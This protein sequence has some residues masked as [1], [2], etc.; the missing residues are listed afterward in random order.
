MSTSQIHPVSTWG[1]G[2]S[3]TAICT[4]SS[5]RHVSSNE[6]YTCGTFSGTVDLNPD[7][8]VDNVTELNTSG[9]VTKY[10]L[11]TG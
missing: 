4:S 1:T 8:G 9:Y 5:A 7:S 2:G 3:G 10:N 6:L 11:L